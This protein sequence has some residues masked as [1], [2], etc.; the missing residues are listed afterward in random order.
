MQFDTILSEMWHKLSKYRKPLVN[1]YVGA[2]YQ[3]WNNDVV[4]FY[5]CVI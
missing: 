3:D 5:I 1:S 4:E 2:K